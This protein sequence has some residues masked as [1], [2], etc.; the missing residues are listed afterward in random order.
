MKAQAIGWVSALAV[1]AAASVG[2][3]SGNGGTIGTGGRT[4]ASLREF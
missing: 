2:C 1:A 4:G 3:G